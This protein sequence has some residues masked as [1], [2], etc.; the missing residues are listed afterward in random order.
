MLQTSYTNVSLV[1]NRLYIIGNKTLE[2]KFIATNENK[3]MIDIILSESELSEKSEDFPS[4]CDK[5]FKEILNIQYGK[6]EMNKLNKEY[7]NFYE[8]MICKA[9]IGKTYIYPI[10][11]VADSV[12]YDEKP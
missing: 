4:I 12:P 8:V 11:N 2:S 1:L 6:M 9:A 7:D 5:G 10:K 3:K